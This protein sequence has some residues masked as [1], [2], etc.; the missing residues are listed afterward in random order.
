MSTI[1]IIHSPNKHQFYNGFHLVETDDDSISISED[2][3]IC[4]SH[5]RNDKIGYWPAMFVGLRNSI[6]NP[7]KSESEAIREYLNWHFSRL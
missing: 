3:R 7:P 2:S 5:E 1:Y 6:I 4:Y